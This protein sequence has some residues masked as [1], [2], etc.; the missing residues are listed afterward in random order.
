M[1]ENGIKIVPFVSD[2]KKHVFEMFAEFGIEGTRELLYEQKREEVA[3]GSKAS[4]KKK[5]RKDLALKT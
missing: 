3:E 4:S 1:G 5:S 2:H